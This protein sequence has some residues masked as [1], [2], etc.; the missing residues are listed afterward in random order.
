MSSVL[1]EQDGVVTR[2]TLNRPERRNA[3]SLDTLGELDKALASVPSDARVVVLGGAGP[4]FSAGHDLAEMIDRPTEFYE[5]LFSRCVEVMQRIHK[6]PQPVIARVHGV[7]TAAGCQLVAACDLAIAS[8]DARFGTPGV[9]I[10]LFCSTPIVPIS[11]AVGPKRSMEMLLT[12]R[13]IDAHTAASWGLVNK[14]VPA[15]QLDHEIDTWVDEI[16]EFSGPVIGLG[17][18]AFHR[19]VGLDEPRAY[20]MAKEVMVVNAEMADAQEGMGAFLEK[21]TPK[22]QGQEQS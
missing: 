8:E 11:R 6:M 1:A 7:A 15:D 18:E 9:K 12:G 2:I 13:Q 10:G 14:V 21:R 17:K 3:L 5:E 22:W 19:Q 4:A 20:E 16:V